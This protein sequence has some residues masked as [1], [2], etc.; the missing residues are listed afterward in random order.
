MP[1]WRSDPCC[2]DVALLVRQVGPGA[3]SREL[4]GQ[5]ERSGAARPAM[6]AQGITT[7]SAVTSL[8]PLGPSRL[9]HRLQR[10]REQSISGLAIRVNI[11]SPLPVNIPSPFRKAVTRWRCGQDPNLLGGGNRRHPGTIFTSGVALLDH[12]VRRL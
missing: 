9:S 11:H 7:S 6:T 8:V 12:S 2:A 1:S 3:T 4:E 10:K 5:S